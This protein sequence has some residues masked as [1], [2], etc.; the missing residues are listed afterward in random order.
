MSQIILKLS[1]SQTGSFKWSSSC[2]FMLVQKTLWCIAIPTRAHP[3]GPQFGQYGSEGKSPFFA[4][5][6]LIKMQ[7]PGAFFSLTEKRD[8]IKNSIARLKFGD[9]R[10]RGRRRINS[11]FGIHLLCEKALK[12]HISRLAFFGF[13]LS[14]NRGNSPIPKLGFG[15]YW[16]RSQWFVQRSWGVWKR[17]SFWGWRGSLEVMTEVL[18][19]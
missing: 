8:K 13:A 19:V 4:L 7:I 12:I 14:L 1:L 16:L 18:E 2:I 9:L 11:L 15:L 5:L 6:L 10:K 3:H 17:I